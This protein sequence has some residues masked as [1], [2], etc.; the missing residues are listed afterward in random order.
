MA[1]ILL[2]DDDTSVIEILKKILDLSGYRVT[3]ASNGAEGIKILRN[4]NYFDLIWGKRMTSLM[5]GISV[6][7]ITTR[8][9]PMPSPAVGGI[10]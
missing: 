7:N 9:I 3:T 8:S 4:K 5:D 1:Q 6:N 2:V 10:P